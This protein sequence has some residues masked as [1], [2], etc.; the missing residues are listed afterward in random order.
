MLFYKRF[1]K[2]FFNL[3]GFSFYLFFF[4]FFRERLK[5]NILNAFLH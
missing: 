5:D 3:K 2:I 1:W 4:E